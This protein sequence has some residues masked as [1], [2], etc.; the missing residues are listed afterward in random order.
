MYDIPY[1]LFNPWA[2]RKCAQNYNLYRS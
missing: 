1:L 2:R